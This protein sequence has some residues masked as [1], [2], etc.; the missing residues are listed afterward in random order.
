MK[1]K[2]LLI[3][4]SILVYMALFAV[5]A[6][7]KEPERQA[8]TMTD[9]SRLMPVKIKQ[10]VKGKEKET[11]VETIKEA[12]RK[13]LKISIAGAQHS[14][15]G[16]TYYEDG[17]VL[18]MTGYNKILG[19]DRKKKI[20]RVQAG[21]TWNDIQRYV[22]PYGLAVKVMQ[23]Q[24][25]FTIGG[26][27]S[28]NAHGRDIRYGSL[29][30]TVKSFHLL[31]A[32]GKVITVTPKDDL[33]SAVIGG[34]GLFGVILDADIEL[35]DDELYEMKT[36]RMNADTYSQYF[37]QHV[38]RNPA[39]RMH[40]A[41]IATGDKGFLHDM[42]VTD[43]TLSD[44]QKEL[45]RH[46]ELKEDEH[47]ALTKFALGLSRRYDWGRNWFWSTQQS[48]FLSQNGVKVSRN[49]VMRSESKFLEY[50]NTD[51][52]DVLQ[53]YFVPVGE[54]APYIHDLRKTLSH[55]DLNLVNITIR[56]VQKNEKADLSYAKEDMFSLVL[57]I[58]EGFSKD[59]QASAARIVRK[60]TDTAL[61]HRGSYYLPYML[62]QTKEQM[63]EAY[64]KSDMFFQK[65]HK[66][67]PDDLFMN[68]FYQRYKS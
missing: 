32:D 21:A 50:E 11:L 61:R 43:Y 40:L 64:P 56:Y 36:K 13:H 19:L 48:Y 14:M 1:K 15:G 30:D 52:T 28:A 4:L 55:E 53:E 24:N 9:V 68:Y 46:N 27:L 18:D 26:S 65:K 5:S 37:T 45:K 6:F 60:M 35:T 42:Y 23:S 54:F 8:G 10:T 63:R 34:Y 39:V 29:I 2:L 33:F 25:I 22:N 3:I 31:K 12:K 16:Q 57:L 49:N 17:I 41:R 58:N 7:H 47:P 38:Q 66:Y 59:S 62:Y 44:N 51:N 20:I 67:D